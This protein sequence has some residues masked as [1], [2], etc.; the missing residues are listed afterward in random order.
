MKPIRIHCAVWVLAANCAWFPGCA[1]GPGSGAGAGDACT[2]FVHVNV[3]PMDRERVLEDATVLVRGDRIAR[4]GRASD[5]PVPAG[6]RIIEGAGSWLMPGLTDMHVHR[7]DEVSC[8]LH[9][10]QGVTRVRNMFGGPRD[11]HLRQI[12]A[13]GRMP[14]PAIVTAGPLVDGPSPVWPGSL[15]VETPEDAREVVALHGRMGYDLVKVYGGLPLG[16]WEEVIRSAAVAGLPVVGHVPRAVGLERA[17][18]MRQ[19]SIEHLEGW[20]MACQREGSPLLRTDSRPSV[21]FASV[22]AWIDFARIPELAAR[23]RAAGAWNCPTLVVLEMISKLDDHAGLSRSPELRFLPPLQLASWDPAED[24]RFRRWGPVHYA[25]LR[26]VQEVNF[27]FVRALRDA[28][29]GIVAGTDTPNPFVMPGFGLREELRLLVRA[30]LTPFESLAAATCDAARCLGLERESGT[31]AQGLRAD[32]LLL[33]GNP[34]EDA[35]RVGDR[36]G[37]MAGGRWFPAA[38]LDRRLETLAAGF[39]EPD[40]SRRLAARLAGLPSLPADRLPGREGRFTMTAG[41]C[42]VGMA[43]FRED[44]GGGAWTAARLV[45]DA[46]HAVDI[47]ID[48]DDSTEGRARLRV[49]GTAGAWTVTGIVTVEPGRV[50]ARLDT[51]FGPVQREAP[52]P[53]SAVLLID[54]IPDLSVPLGRLSS[55]PEGP[56][57]EWSAVLLDIIEPDLRPLSVTAQRLAAPDGSEAVA[58]G[59]RCAMTWQDGGAR[60]TRTL[61]FDASSRLTEVRAEGLVGA[62][63]WRRSR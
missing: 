42:C 57:E 32:L 24:F 52:F 26:L 4:V 55:L 14:G 18:A 30:G 49:S 16:A 29:A 44:A 36:V 12:V 20:L 8:L 60:V 13:E 56:G 33:G 1:S 2:A 62:S 37:V 23:A 63:G 40:L 53:E 9:L 22:V 11:L 50:V 51:P 10:S 27:R 21:D 3:I 7:L 45:R 41:S 17:L 43:R 48:R 6:A 54:E 47:A 28:G 46:P 19:H 5:V 25:T 38:D 61:S 31:I 58:G 35:G 39:R 34:L 59:F 15:K